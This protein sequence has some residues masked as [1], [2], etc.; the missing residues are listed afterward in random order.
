MKKIMYFAA[1]LAALTACSKPARK[2]FHLTG[3]PDIVLSHNGE[4]TL[5][6]IEANPEDAWTLTADADWFSVTQSFGSGDGFRGTGDAVIVVLSDRWTMNS[7]RT[8]TI[9]V[10]GPTGAFTKTL[11]QNP[12]PVPEAPLQLKGSIPFSG[13][14]SRIALPEGYWVK[15]ESS[16]SWLTVFNCQEGELTV[17]AGENPVVDRGREA[18]VHVYLSDGTLLA[19]VTV[20]QNSEKIPAPVD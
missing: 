2:D 3:F 12:K 6:G 11:T 4:S 16:E 14:E 20:S 10:T 17:S 8:G 19:E 18:V 1:L 15:A 9:T 5:F 13:S 7:I